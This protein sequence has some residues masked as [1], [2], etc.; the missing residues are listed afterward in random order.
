MRLL[1]CGGRSYRDYQNV[2]RRIELLRPSVVI[3]GAYKGADMLA[4]RA[5][6]ALGIPVEPYPADWDRLGAAA[7]PVRN[8]R[9]IDEGKPDLVLAFQGADGT[10]D[11]IRRAKAA[12]ICVREEF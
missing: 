5:A 4:D 7:G 3:H 6:R 11:M 8:Q 1:V 10:K 2:L 12:G 9:M